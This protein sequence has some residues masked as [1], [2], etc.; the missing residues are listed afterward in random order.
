MKVISDL[1]E[2]KPK[3]LCNHKAR[4]SEITRGSVQLNQYGLYNYTLGVHLHTFYQQQFLLYEHRMK[5]PNHQIQYWLILHYCDAMMGAMVSQITGVTI[6]YSTVCSGADQRKRQSSASLAFVR[7]TH[8]WSV[9]SLHKGPGTRQM[10]SFDDVIIS[11]WLILTDVAIC[12][13]GLWITIVFP[14]EIR[15]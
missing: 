15:K 12:C 6:V 3:E 10:L 5:Q 9:N 13:P 1:M 11:Y 14:M 7:G 8:R 4:Y 2:L